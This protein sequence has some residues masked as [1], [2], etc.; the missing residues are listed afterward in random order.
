MGIYEEL[1]ERGYL[2][3]STDFEQI[4]EKLNNEKVTFYI[5]FDPTADSLTAGHFLALMAMARL[6]RAGHKPIVL[7]GGGTVMIGDPTGKT[8][9]RKMLDNEAIDYNTQRFKMQMSK[10]IDFDEDK[11]IVVNNG[12]WL[13]KLNYVEFLRDI[14]V[15]FT[16][17]RML[18]AECFKSRY[19]RGLT[20]IEFNYMIMQSYDFLV[21]NEKYGCTMQFGGDDQWSNM[22]GGVDLIR[23]KTAKEAYCLTFN[24]LTTSDGKKMGK[25]EKGAVWL[26]PLKTTP[27]EF[28]QYWRNIEDG[29]VIELMK[30][31][32]FMTLDE[33]K[34]YE[35]AS[36]INKS[37]EKLAYE[38]TALVHSAEEA[39]EALNM[40]KSL[41][42]GGGDNAP[43]FELNTEDFVDG[44]IGILDILVKVKFAPSRGEAR[45]LI[46]QGGVLVDNERVAAAT[47]NF[48]IDKI[49][50]S[51]LQKG[52]K[53][54]LKIVVKS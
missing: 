16:V 41:F 46:E 35:N 11:A 34:E 43:V 38:L 50:G 29:K 7:L 30:L 25:T 31:L 40:A 36:D 26:D 19:E 52:K 51:L 21:L 10:F 22:L 18:A 33:I 27:Y 12:D 39:D 1:Q 8:D 49:N 24:L 17:N 44:N 14:G 48:S 45:R 4:K 15:H 2:A 9:M 47:I 53:N 5:G 54:F 37:K 3:Q 20:F 13:L 6:Q 23:R 28:F 42:M 32:T